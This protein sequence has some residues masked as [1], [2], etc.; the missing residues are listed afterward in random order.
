M[1]EYAIS[2]AEKILDRLAS[3]AYEEI[4]LAWGAKG[5]L[6]KLTAT[7]KTIQVVL[8][9]I[10]SGASSIKGRVRQFFSEWNSL[11]FNFKLAH[12][13]KEVR[14]RLEV[15]A[16]EKTHYSLAEREGDHWRGLHNNDTTLITSDW[17]VEWLVLQ[18]IE[19]VIN[20]K[21][22]ILW[23][24]DCKMLWGVKSFC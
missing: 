20:I 12:K 1:G 3:Y 11:I 19:N 9:W 4:I 15:I 6:N 10:S 17:F 24:E 2:S 16:I 21:V 5:E 7:L 8:L 18:L 13:I 22:W 14:E 23:K